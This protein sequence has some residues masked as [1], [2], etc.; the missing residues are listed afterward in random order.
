MSFTINHTRDVAAP[1]ATLWQV[2]IDLGAYAEWNPFVVGCRSTLVVGE[3]IDMRVQIFSSFTQPQRETILEHDEGRHLC[4]GLA[5][6]ILGAI[7]SRRCHGV[8]AV[9]GLHSRYHSTFELSGWLVPVVGT[10]LGSRLVHGFN[11]MT[12]ALVER[13]EQLTD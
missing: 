12:N 2:V 7:S 1:A 8:E 13:A 4:Y 5:P 3:P 11:A 6:N 9:D 10:L